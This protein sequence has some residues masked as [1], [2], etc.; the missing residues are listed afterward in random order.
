MKNPVIL[1]LLIFFGFVCTFFTGFYLA[2]ILHLE[3]QPPDSSSPEPLSSEATGSAGLST[4]FLP[5]KYYFDDA[6]ILITK[7][8]PH[9][10]IAATVSRS[11]QA[12][13]YSQ[14]TRISYFDGTNWTRK[15]A[16]DK[17]AD[18]EM[19][20]NQFLK[21]W[22]INYD[23]SRVL[24]ETVSAKMMVND[25]NI[26]F[27]S[28]TLQNEIAMRSI[29]GYTKFMSEGKNAR[30]T[31]NGTEHPA[32]IIYTKIYSFNAKDLQFYNTPL[33]VTTDWIAF[34]DKNGEFYHVDRTNVDKPTEIYQS[35]EIGVYKNITGSVNK[36]FSVDSSHDSLENPTIFTMKLREPVYASLSLKMIN[37]F[38]KYPDTAYNWFM[39]Q[40][41]GEVEK[42]DK[43]TVS[44]IGV[45][46]YIHD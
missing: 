5:G 11:Q 40:A 42:E 34:W 31:I 25:V 15:M 36:S 38:N 27:L 33:G 37:Q 4:P 20:K 6:A 19:M 2:T 14:S 28:G 18:S 32:Y 29:P 1:L 44:G 17:A 39:G 24:K 12:E 45:V 21:K 41:V 10:T 43:T 7:D 13:G 16:Q 3:L 26:E 35:H 23:P 46:E 8:A 9:Y 22:E 30:I